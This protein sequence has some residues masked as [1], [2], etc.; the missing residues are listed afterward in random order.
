MNSQL[1]HRALVVEDDPSWQQI[2]TE[3]LSDCS[4]EVDAV[5]T[6]PEALALAAQGRHDLAVVDLSLDA[7]D[8]HNRS[9][10]QVLDSLKS[11]N[12][13][14]QAI[15]LTGFATV[16][17]AV[18]ALTEH[19]ALTCLRKEAF[20]RQSFLRLVKLSLQA[21]HPI[22]GTPGE[23]NEEPP[24]S[25]PLNAQPPSNIEVRSLLV[26]VVEDDPGWQKILAELL[27]ESGQVVHMCS[28]FGEALGRLR[29]EKY[30]LAIID[31]SLVEGSRN[32]NYPAEQAW[33]AP[34][35]TGF[36]LL[37]STRAA[38]IPTIVVSGVSSPEEIERAYEE[39]GIFAYLQKQVFA[40]KAFLGTVSEALSAIPIP[41]ELAELTG[42]ERQVFNLLAQGM[43]NKEISETLVISTNTVKR[44]LKAI[45]GKLHI[46]TRS[47]AAKFKTYFP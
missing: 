21:V 47:A 7:S 42:R 11:A 41:D 18:S 38:G 15:L 14:C 2:L 6:L 9:G 34:D 24:G 44:H 33:Q 39:Y 12:P 40:R 32:W 10:L 16:E 37:A 27:E 4:L 43:T 19:G 29:R 31:L 20:Q 28:G 22:P 5:A 17:L 8:P 35:F 36:R 46:H 25:L 3:I 45:F 30:A 26:L 1:P 13:T 23:S